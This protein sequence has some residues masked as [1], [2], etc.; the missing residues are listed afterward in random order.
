MPYDAD[1]RAGYCVIE[2]NMTWFY[3]MMTDQGM[4]VVFGP[5]DK[6]G[7]EDVYACDTQKGVIRAFEEHIEGAFGDFAIYKTIGHKRNDRAYEDYADVWQFLQ[8][9]AID[10]VRTNPHVKIEDENDE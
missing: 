10:Y 4:T 8:D 2:L 1:P 9:E 6:E 5:F 7:E 3:T